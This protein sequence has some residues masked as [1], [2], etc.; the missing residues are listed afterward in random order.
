MHGEGSVASAARRLGAVVPLLLL[1][2]CSGPRKAVPTAADSTATI[3]GELADPFV[4]GSPPYGSVVYLIPVTLF[5]QD[6]WDGLARRQYALVDPAYDGRLAFTDRTTCALGGRFQF[7]HVRPGDYYVYSRVLWAMAMGDSTIFGGRAWVAAAKVSAGDTFR[8]TLRPPDTT[9]ILHPGVGRI[10][11]G[12][13]PAPTEPGLPRFGEYVYFDELPVALTKVAPAYPAAAREAGVDG[14]V[15]VQALVGKDG[16]VKDTR[17]VKS[18]PMLDEAAE[19]A[20]R[21]WVFKP[22]LSNNRPV[23]VWVAVPVK[24]TR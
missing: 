21:H 3:V 24:F 7:T 5:S 1:L 14:T 11:R 10:G 13:W 12:R 2:G 20:V 15:L 19:T 17:V 8:L 6:W 16:R 9:L 18:I 22:A 4:H 23:A